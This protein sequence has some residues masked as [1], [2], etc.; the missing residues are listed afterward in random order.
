M[1]SSYRESFEEKAHL[2]GDLVGQRTDRMGGEPVDEVAYAW[3]DLE[4][5]LVRRRLAPEEEG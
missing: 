5:P 4:A 2:G 1:I 3:R